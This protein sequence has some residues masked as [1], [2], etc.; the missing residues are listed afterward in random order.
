MQI[1]TKVR[2]RYFTNRTAK[3]KKTAHPNYWQVELPHTTGGNEHD[4]VILES[5]LTVFPLHKHQIYIYIYVYSIYEYEYICV[6]IYDIISITY[7]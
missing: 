6:D 5:S 7:I 4:I 3:I 2:Y 1:K